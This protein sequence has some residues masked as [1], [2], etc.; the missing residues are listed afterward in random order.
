MRIYLDRDAD[1]SLIR[2]KRLAIIG[3]GSQGEAHALNLRDSGVREVA[4]ALRPG[5]KSEAAARAAGFKLMDVAEAARCADVMM[6]ATPDELQ[7]GIY[8]QHLA[9]HMKQGAALVFLHG[10]AIHFGFI[11]P[12]ADMDVL[13][14]APKG[15][16]IALRQQYE[17]GSG[18]LCLVAVQQDASGGAHALGLSYA[19]G[20]G[21]GRVGILET[22]FSEEAVTDLFGEQAVLCGG[23]V[24]MIRAGYE[25]LVEAGYSPEMAYLDCVHEVKLIVDLI[26]ERGIAD[27]YNAISN[28]AEFGAY[29]TGPRLVTD[30]TRAE[31]KRVLDD[32]RSG[33]FA[34]DWMAENAQGQ[35]NFKERREREAAREINAT[36][37]RLRA[38]MPWLKKSKP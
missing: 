7:A 32:V 24:E 15:P 19:A 13:M 12:R 5:S 16:G 37:A 1:L 11:K 3:F 33:K 10:F 26:Y 38:L 2:G 18:L 22:K 36:G 35:R 28:T 21:G 34:R 17:K 30:A 29:A 9:P 8:E 27:M 6:I 31:M 14:V 23:V 20:I 25:T 4:I